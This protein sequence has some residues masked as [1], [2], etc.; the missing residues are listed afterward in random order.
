MGKQIEVLELLEKIKETKKEKWEAAKNER[1]QD[2][3]DGRDK[4]RVLMIR[5]DEITGVESCYDKIFLSEE[6]LENINNIVNSTERLKKI[7][8]KSKEI[9][10]DLDFDK[11]LL[12]L[13]KQRD[14]A[15]VNMFQLKEFLGLEE[16]K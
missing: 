3:A 4:Q 8:P 10:G 5:L 2:A 14:E 1:Y 6:I 13:Y 15:F 9:F 12:K 16:K 7:R 11:Y